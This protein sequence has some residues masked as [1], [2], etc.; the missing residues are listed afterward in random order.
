[1]HGKVLKMH[2]HTQ[3]VKVICD[4]SVA[5]KNLYAWRK[6]WKTLKLAFWDLNPKPNLG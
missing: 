1:M 6:F 5:V 2:W 3:N 4:Q